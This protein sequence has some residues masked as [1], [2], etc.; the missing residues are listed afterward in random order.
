MLQISIRTFIRSS[1]QLWNHSVLP[2][3]RL[4]ESRTNG[5]RVG[6]NRCV[7]YSKDYPSKID[8]ITSSLFFNFSS[9][10]IWIDCDYLFNSFPGTEK[11][12]I[13]FSLPLLSL[14]LSLSLSLS[15]FFLGNLKC[16]LKKRR[17]F[18]F[19]NFFF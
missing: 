2:M 8:T 3:R 17:A 6:S 18:F 19:F 13:F 4:L 12:Y 1:N 5:S 10:I 7:L 16:R 11:A 14:F 15:F 9:Y